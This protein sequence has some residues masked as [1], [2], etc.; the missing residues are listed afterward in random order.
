MPQYK[1][2]AVN[3]ETKNWSSKYG[4]MVTYEIKLEGHDYPVQLNQKPETPAPTV[5]QELNGDIENGNFPDGALYYRFKKTSTFG[6]GKDYTEQLN[7]IEEMLK[8]LVA[9]S[10]GGGAVEPTPAVPN[11]TNEGINPIPASTTEMP[12]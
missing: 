4:P 8:T 2:T 1:V 5:G 9:G 10:Q 12:W 7:R 6:G 11:V 3:P